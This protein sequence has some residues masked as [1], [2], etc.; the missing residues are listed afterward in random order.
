MMTQRIFSAA[1]LAAW[2]L[3]LPGCTGD[4][5]AAPVQTGLAG[6]WRWISSSGGFAGET[7]TPASA[8]YTRIV[9]YYPDG[10]YEEYRNSAIARS[11]RYTL[12][13]ETPPTRPDQKDVV[14]YADDPSVSQIVTLSGTDTLFL[15]D[16]CM[17]CYGH[18][19]VHIP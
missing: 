3:S 2:F 11:T 7:I 18:T 10:R 15:Y 4:H 12:V 8:G 13:R 17:D 5:A 1:L 16:S 9:V 19:Y 14:Y 6:S